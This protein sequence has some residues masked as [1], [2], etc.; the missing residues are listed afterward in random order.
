[1]RHAK[2]K[3]IDS[4]DRDV[5]LSALNDTGPTTNSEAIPF[6][7]SGGFGNASGAA[8]V[9]ATVRPK[10]TALVTFNLADGAN[11]SGSR[12]HCSSRFLTMD[13]TRQNY[14]RGQ[15]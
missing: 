15:P 8:G 6:N 4:L 11:P 12:R 5:D 7:D 14:L 3:L 1:M 2:L 10:L 13:V 9:A